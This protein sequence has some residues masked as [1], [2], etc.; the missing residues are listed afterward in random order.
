MK[1]L[2]HIMPNYGSYGINGYICIAVGFANVFCKTF[3]EA[4]SWCKKNN[5]DYIRL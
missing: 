3:K 1:I 5:L 2:A 4:T